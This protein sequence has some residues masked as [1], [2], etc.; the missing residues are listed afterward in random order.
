MIFHRVSNGGCQSYV[1]GCPE[2]CVAAL[3][4]PCMA[5][6]DRY[7]GLLAREGMTL[8]YVIDTHTHADHFSAARTLGEAFGV[9]VVMHRN[10]P[11][12][13]VDLLLEDGD[14]VAVGDM[15]VHVLYTPGHTVDSMCLVLEDRVFTGDTL[16]IGGTGRTDLP[17][18]DPEALHDSLF[19]RLL[20]LDPAT[21]VFPAHDYKDQ[22]STTI[23]REI[24]ENPRLQQRDRGAFVNMMQHLNLSAPDHMREALRTNLSGGKTVE[25]LLREARNRV[26]FIGPAT[27]HGQISAGA[28]DLLILDVRE[29]APYEDGHIVGARHLPRGQIE[30]RVNQELPD[31]TLRIVTICEFGNV[32]TL[33]AATLRDLGFN[34]AVALDGGLKAWR[35]ADLPLEVGPAQ[36]WL[37]DYPLI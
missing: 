23:G 22:V 8:R 4:D 27:L 17:T 35:E 20:R 24:A 9:P 19:N 10:T 37:E 12:A 25:Q 3:I 6:I 5:Q 29:R 31:P 2:R 32:S 36:E 15:R 21:L 11:V 26:P 16:L 7:R 34:R 28:N 13:N 18:G 14:T 30:L 33:A 1:V